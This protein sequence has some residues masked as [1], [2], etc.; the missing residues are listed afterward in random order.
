MQS[1][2]ADLGSRL[3]HQW[4]LKVAAMFIAA[5]L[6]VYVLNQQNPMVVKEYEIP[7]QV[8]NVP[9]GTELLTLSPE[10]V[11]VVVR[12]RSSLLSGSTPPLSVRV[13][14]S[15]GNVGGQDVPVQIAARPPGLEVVSLSRDYVRVRLDL[16]V[17]TTRPV[18]VETPGLPAEGYRAYP[19]SSQ[20]ASVSVS[21]PASMVQRVAKVVATLDISGLSASVSQRVKV[22][23]R[24]EIGLT[25]PRVRLDPEMVRV[26]VPIRPV[27]TKLLPLWP[28]VGPVPLGYRLRRLSAR[29]ASVVVSA[30]PKILRGL[31]TLRTQR[32]DISDLRGTRTYT[33]R[34]RVPNGVS[35][36][37]PASTQVTVSLAPLPM[38]E[39]QP[40]APATSA[41]TPP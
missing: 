24:D 40:A 13:D 39:V 4:P 1:F 34:L 30:S 8:I 17:T 28:D 38:P 25:V 12:G 14:L 41:P 15:G 20:P 21:G 19:P 2:L 36:L 31:Q 16:A 37:G 23:P 5:A 29:P 10:T 26:T 7:V 33:V 32:I 11:K 18:V 6:W 35:V 3:T 22:Q 27:N 9:E